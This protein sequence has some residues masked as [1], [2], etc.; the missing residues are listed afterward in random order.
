MDSPIIVVYSFDLIVQPK[1]FFRGFYNNLYRE[2]AKFEVACQCFG[3]KN[4]EGL[5][6]RVDGLEQKF[7]GIY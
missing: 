7:K 2:S 6:S 3:F 4:V 5:N 1:D